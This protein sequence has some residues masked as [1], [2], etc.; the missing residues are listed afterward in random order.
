[1]ADKPNDVEVRQSKIHGQGLYAM[2]E[3]SPGEIVV[4]WTN[5][6]EL[7][8]AELATLPEAERRYLEVQNKKFILV[9]IPERFIN[10][11]CSPN[12]TPGEFCDIASRHIKLGE[13]ITCDYA[14]FT[15]PGGKMAC[16]CDA[17]NC[18]KII[19]GRNE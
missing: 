18:R 6:R 4:R 1:M 16:F 3:F 11:S 15:I 13:E 12:T 9:G 10:H 2:R 8:P 19:V 17:P 14:N 7:S 5:S